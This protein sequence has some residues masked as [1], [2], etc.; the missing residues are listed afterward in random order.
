MKAKFFYAG[1]RVKD[2]EASVKF[3]TTLLGDPQ[4][5]PF[6]F[7]GPVPGGQVQRLDGCNL[8]L[9]DDFDVEAIV[10]VQLCDSDGLGIFS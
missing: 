5:V 1:I 7:L 4:A 3:Y 10:R 9:R 8:C 6:L 2:L